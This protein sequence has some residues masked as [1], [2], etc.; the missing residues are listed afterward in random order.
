MQ[1]QQDADFQHWNVDFGAVQQ[2]AKELG[3]DLVRRPVCIPL[4]LVHIADHH[5]DVCD[6]V[7]DICTSRL[8]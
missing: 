2:R 7:A 5:N 1:L 8:P 3:I 6:V 4:H